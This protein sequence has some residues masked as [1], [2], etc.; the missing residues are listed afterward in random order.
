MAAVAAAGW[1]RYDAEAHRLSLTLHVQPNARRDAICGT[2][3]DTLKIRIAAP[4][5]DNRANAALRKLFAQMLNVTAAAVTIRRGA[6]G[7]RKVLVIAPVE[8][9]AARRL[10]AT[11]SASRVSSC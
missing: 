5:A 3:G 10:L 6:T 8:E 1:Y 11:A 4:A 7:R 9:S 2:H